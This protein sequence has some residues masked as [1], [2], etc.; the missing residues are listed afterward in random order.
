[1]KPITHTFLPS[2]SAARNA[3]AA[4]GYM[5]FEGKL[6]PPANGLKSTLYAPRG[7]VTTRHVTVQKKD[8]DVPFCVL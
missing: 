6:T 5:G 8:C 3:R 4:V 1:M 2:L 7:A